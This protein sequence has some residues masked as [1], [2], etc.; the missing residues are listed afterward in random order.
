MVQENMCDMHFKENLQRYIIV[1]YVAQSL[2]KCPRVSVGF[3]KS[4]TFLNNPTQV[5]Q[6]FGESGGDRELEEKKNSLFRAYMIVIIIITA[7]ALQNKKF[8]REVRHYISTDKI[9]EQNKR[10][11]H[12][13]N[14]MA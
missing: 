14:K 7:I 4:S 12:K 6:H 3:S 8:D 13:H 1:F 9:T 11:G 2:Q 5:Q 10:H